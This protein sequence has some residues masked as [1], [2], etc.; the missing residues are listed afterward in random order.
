VSKTRFFLRLVLVLV[1]A[2]LAPCQFE[3]VS[4]NLRIVTHDL[5][6]TACQCVNNALLSVIVLQTV[7]M[8]D[9]VQHLV[10]Q[11]VSNNNIIQV[12]ANINDP[13]LFVALTVRLGGDQLQVSPRFDLIGSVADAD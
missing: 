11:R 2:S 12:R 8:P 4:N 9:S 1:M 7:L 5:N 6:Q 3:Q 10:K 13:T